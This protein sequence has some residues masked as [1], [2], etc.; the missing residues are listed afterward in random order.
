VTE[1]PVTGAHWIPEDDPHGMGRALASW[2]T[3]L[4][5]KPR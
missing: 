1:A 5:R 2:F 4:D 3:D